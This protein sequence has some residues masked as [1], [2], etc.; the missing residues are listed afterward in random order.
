M[1]KNALFIVAQINFHNV[2]VWFWW[3]WVLKGFTFANVLW[4]EPIHLLPYF[5]RSSVSHRFPWLSG[6]F[7][8]SLQCSTGSRSV[9]IICQAKKC[10]VKQK[11]KNHALHT[12]SI[13]MLDLVSCI[14]PI[15]YGVYY[16]SER[17]F[18]PRRTS[19]IRWGFP[20][21]RLSILVWF[22]STRATRIKLSQPDIFHLRIFRMVGLRRSELFLVSINIGDICKKSH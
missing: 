14:N 18:R 16:F 10:H 9:K 19:T 22:S 5:S 8:T 20:Q 13:E 1:Y 17:N 2:E 4:R 7:F 15:I 11:T 3:N 12:G 6:T 21:S